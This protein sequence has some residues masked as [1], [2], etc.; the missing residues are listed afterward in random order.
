VAAPAAPAVIVRSI[1]PSKAK[2]GDDYV[3]PD[4]PPRLSF[5]DV[6]GVSPENIKRIERTVRAVEQFGQFMNVQ[7]TSKLL[8]VD[9]FSVR[10]RVREIVEIAHELVAD[11]KVSLECRIE[12]GHMATA[13]SRAYTELVKQA[14]ELAE[15]TE[16][17]AASTEKRKVLPPPLAVQVNVNSGAEKTTTTLS[18]TGGESPSD[19]SDG[20]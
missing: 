14:V 18:A 1:P 19:E 16:E 12:A 4:A 5:R 2:R 20:D 9:Q 13:A 6:P 3:F 8:W 11:N 10:E 15:K 17:K 7:V